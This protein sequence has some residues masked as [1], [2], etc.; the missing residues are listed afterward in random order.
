M[1]FWSVS[2]HTKESQITGMRKKDAK[3]R[4]GSFL[5]SEA[6]QKR[7]VNTIQSIIAN[8]I[9]AFT[10]TTRPPS[11]RPDLWNI[12]SFFVSF[13]VDRRI[14]SVYTLFKS[15]RK[16]VLAGASVLPRSSGDTLN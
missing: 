13:C 11:G 8:W 3:F 14:V 16:T 2:E 4:P 1:S 5:V 12:V 6:S 9:P 10:G 7:L 15:C